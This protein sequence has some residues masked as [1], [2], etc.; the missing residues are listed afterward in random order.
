MVGSLVAGWFWVSIGT[1]FVPSVSDSTLLD[2]SDR[3]NATG[4][5]K[6]VSNFA[7]AS[8]P[9][10]RPVF[11]GGQHAST[12]GSDSA[13]WKGFVCNIVCIIFDGWVSPMRH[14]ESSHSSE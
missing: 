13:E 2:P 12:I 1:S 9:I 4:V 14:R 8:K 10:R 5:R 11:E 6:C 3:F 7:A